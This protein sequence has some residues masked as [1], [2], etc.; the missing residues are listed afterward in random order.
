MTS[1]FPEL[2]ESALLGAF[3]DFRDPNSTCLCML[4]SSCKSLPPLFHGSVNGVQRVADV[5]QHF[6]EERTGCG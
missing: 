5:R 6:G 3:L 2:P 4:T 1:M